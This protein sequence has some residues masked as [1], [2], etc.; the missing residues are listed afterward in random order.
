MIGPKVAA[1]ASE[2]EPDAV[3]KKRLE[4]QLRETLGDRVRSLEVRVSGRNVLVA[5]KPAWFW[6]RRGVKRSIETA[7]GLQGYRVRID[8]DD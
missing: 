7:P 3:V 2:P 1:R 8:L 5:A 6:L 4:K